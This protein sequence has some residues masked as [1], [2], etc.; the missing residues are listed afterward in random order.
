METPN[1]A[2]NALPTVTI[3]S[4]TN[5]ETVGSD[6]TV[7]VTANDSDGSITGVMIK[8]GSAAY[9]AASGTGPYTL[10]V[11]GESDGALTIMAYAVDNSGESSATNSVNVTV[12]SIDS[13]PPVAGGGLGATL[14][15]VLTVGSVTNSV[16]L[17]WNA[18][19]D[20][21]SAT[22]DLEYEVIYSR[23]NNI[24]T[25]IDATNNGTVG[26]AYTANMTATSV[27]NLLSATRYY[28]NVLVRDEAGNESVYSIAS[29]TTKVGGVMNEE[30]GTDGIVL[31][32]NAAGDGTLE[33]AWDIARDSAGRIFATGYGQNAS[34]NDDMIIVCFKPDGT[35]DTSFGGGDGVVSSDASSGSADQGYA[36]EIAPDGDLVVCGDAGGDM[37][38][39]RY[40]SD[41]NPDTS[42]DGDGLV[43]HDNAAGGSGD[44][45]GYD[46]A[47]DS[48]GKII[49]VGDS[50][51]GSANQTTL[52]IWRY[53]STGVLDTTSFN[54][55]MGYV[56]ND[57]ITG[58]TYQDRA[59]T[60]LLD[61]S[62]SIYAAGESL[63]G[64]KINM[65]ALKYDSSGSIDASFGDAGIIS[66][67]DNVGG[68]S[69]DYAVDMAWANDGDL[70]IIGYDNSQTSGIIWKYNT[71]GTLD[72]GF[73]GGDGI[74]VIP[75]ILVG[76]MHPSA[77]R[78]DEDDLIYISG[79]TYDMTY[80]YAFLMRLDSNG[81]PDTTFGGGDGYIYHRDS[82]EAGGFDYGSDLGGNLLFDDTGRIYTCGYA[83]N[84]TSSVS[85]IALWSYR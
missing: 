70:L 17:I 82:Y 34:G 83:L 22:A 61:G 14:V 35:V 56:T 32:D 45:N 62:D 78:Q 68:N 51:S 64:T 57:S 59:Y 69:S 38:I 65:I 43:I 11:I 77:I 58:S 19:S 67:K 66:N 1:T 30:F 20:D 39:W 54:A 29:N 76:G 71:D 23:S 33:I 3:T 4:P 52:V 85:D 79:Y 13:T 37:A 5:N 84:S 18:A 41:G 48:N 12:A 81:N 55:P 9:A 24:N 63:D 53:T 7:S 50:Y 49:V 26:I 80:I 42:F 21:H 27:T 75:G 74:S 10:N 60:V 16:D 6:F 2:S 40:D 73:G 15:N 72:A 8:I 28:F 44:D 46:L 31:F 25:I 36:I 47:I